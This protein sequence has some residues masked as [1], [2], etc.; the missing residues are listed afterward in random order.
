MQSN[1]MEV[2]KMQKEF[3]KEL[4]EAYRIERKNTH[5]SPYVKIILV[6][7]IV[8]KE[9][10][11]NHKQFEEYLVKIPFQ[12]QGYMVMLSMPMCIMP[13]C[14]VVKRNRSY[15]YFISFYKNNEV[16]RRASS[17]R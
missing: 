14:R 12:Y 9:L 15:Y 10:K 4:L 3:F 13:R 6:R 1:M 2:S 7:K 17:H 8:C 11:I 5:G 16:K